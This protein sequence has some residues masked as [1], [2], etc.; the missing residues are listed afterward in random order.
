MDV[1]TL[2]HGYRNK[3]IEMLQEEL[4]YMEAYILVYGEYVNAKTKV[5]CECLICGYIWDIT[6]NSLL[7]GKGCE[8]CSGNLKLSLQD[9]QDELNLLGKNMR[10]SG[11][12][13]G[14]KSKLTCECLSCG[15]V[16]EVIADSI[17]KGRCPGCSKKVPWTITSIK[18]KL[19]TDKRNIELVSDTYVNRKSI[20]DFKCAICSFEW[21]TALSC[22]LGIHTTGCS[23][24]SKTGFKFLRPANLYYL[25]VTTPEERILYKVGISCKSTLR[26]YSCSETSKIEVLYEYNFKTGLE[27]WVAEKNILKLFREYSYRGPNV[28]TS[29]NT[30]LF[31]KDVLQMGGLTP[32][33]VKDVK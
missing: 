29:G 17:R 33:A 16:R 10:V 31:T 11:E 25:R 4:F 22:V 2:Y 6:P 27:A 23:N 15:L 18:E 5:N 20:L 30:E 13:I 8:R 9:I 14:V 28:L 21:S 32:L 24:C 3:N 7:V 12:Y 19:I 26:R 1:K